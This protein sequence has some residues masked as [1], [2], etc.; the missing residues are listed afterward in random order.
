VRTSNPTQYHHTDCDIFLQKN[1][2][3]TQEKKST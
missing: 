1:V 2:T 3:F